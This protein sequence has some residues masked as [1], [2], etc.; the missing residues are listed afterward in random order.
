MA[1]SHSLEF[2]S[3]IMRATRGRGVHMVL[4]SLA[5][6]KLLVRDLVRHCLHKNSFLGVDAH[7]GNQRTLPRDRQVRSCEQYEATVDLLAAQ[8]RLPRH[9][10]RARYVQQRRVG[11]GR[12]Q[13]YTQNILCLHVKVRELFN[14]GIQT[15]VVQPLPSHV[16]DAEDVEPAFRFLA[17]GK[18]RGAL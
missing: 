12:K 3:H 15:G 13:R 4:N 9:C 14:E 2:E 17:S 7:S 16:Y 6:E 11:A 10:A 18:H 5:D 8:Y 1:D